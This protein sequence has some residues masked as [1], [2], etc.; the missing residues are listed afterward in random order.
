MTR[1][2]ILSLLAIMSCRMACAE[3]P[4][5]SPEELKSESSHIIIGKVRA[6]YS[7]MEKSEDWE[8][9]N[10]VAEI[11]VVGVEKGA[12]INCGDVIYAHYWNKKW[13]GKGD[14]EPHSGGHRGVSKGHSVTAFLERKD[15]GYH[16]LLPSGFAVV[17]PTEAK[18]F[19]PTANLQG[20]WSF[21]FYKENGVIQEPGTKQFVI[22]GDK[23]RF[24][25]G[26]E[27]RIET[28]IEVKDGTL[29]QK[30]ED[31]QVYR[32]LF[33]RVGDLLILCGNR[34][35]DRPTEFAGGTTN[36][37]EFLIVLEKE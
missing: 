8:D 6:V 7:T 9:T 12:G 5:M 35:K 14:P 19:T 13:V 26:G 16:V 21:V 29:D 22:E 3:V 15:G 36:G 25:A 17:K 32:S 33:K 20:T 28:T 11:C 24:R 37:G 4:L 1:I 18:Q 23:L 2:T 31:G 10:S 30:F 34:D 27:T